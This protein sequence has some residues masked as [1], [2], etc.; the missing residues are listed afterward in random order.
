MGRGGREKIRRRRCASV[1]PS[2]WPVSGA[3]AAAVAA[4]P[5]SAAAVAAAARMEHVMT[6]WAAARRALRKAARSWRKTSTASP[7]RHVQKCC[8][9]GGG[10]GEQTRQVM[11]Q[12]HVGEG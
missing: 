11:L 2:H 8:R 5:E 12:A 10:I 4:G 7:A 1:R 6:T 9:G 3:A